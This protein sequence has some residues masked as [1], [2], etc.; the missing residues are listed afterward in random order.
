MP[1][2]TKGDEVKKL[3]DP[4]QEIKSAQDWIVPLASRREG[5]E[6]VIS[7]LYEMEMKSCSP[8]ELLDQLTLNPDNFVLE[9]FMGIC[10]KREQLDLEI[11]ALSKDWEVERMPLIDRIIAEQALYELLFCPEIPT[12]VILSEAVELAQNFSTDGSG[13]FVNG[14]LSAAAKQVRAN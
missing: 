14:L 2:P 11:N 4:Q 8:S 12:G 10:S 3:E 5:R 1:E 6:R 13:K 7:L 9:R